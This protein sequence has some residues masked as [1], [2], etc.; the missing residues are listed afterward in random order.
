M[1]TKNTRPA[2]V[3]PRP[4][5]PVAIP[6]TTGRRAEES[7]LGLLEGGR[8]NPRHSRG[9][10]GAGRCPAGGTPQVL[11]GPGGPQHTD[12]RFLSRRHRPAR[13]QAPSGASFGMTDQL[14]SCRDKAVIPRPGHPSPS[15]R[16][17]GRRAEESTLRYLEGGRGSPRHSRGYTGAGRC[18]AGGRRK[19]WVVQPATSTPTVDSSVGATGLCD[20]QAPSGASFGMTVWVLP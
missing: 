1:C 2:P 12:G 5:P 6:R 3:I 15:L 14:S 8:G 13:W 7:T 9:Y 17:T 20:G 10:T 11:R 4:K 19:S 16:A 18:P